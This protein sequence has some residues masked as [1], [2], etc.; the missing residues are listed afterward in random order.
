[1]T[2][3][4]LIALPEKDDYIY[5]SGDNY[6]CSTMVTKF[7]K[8]GG[9][10]DGFEIDSHE[11][12]QK[13]NYQLKIFEEDSKK[14]PKTCQEQNPDLTYCILSGQYTIDLEGYNTV[15]LHHKKSKN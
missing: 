2:L 15:T 6:V 10:F 14:L 11:F 1:M 13:D 9:L 12:T 3:E 7:W 8:E 4:E 5:S